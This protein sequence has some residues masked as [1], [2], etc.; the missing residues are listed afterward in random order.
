MAD[1]LPFALAYERYAAERTDA[2]AAYHHYA[3]VAICAA[4]LGNRVWVDSCW[5][6]IYPAIWLCFV[7]PSGTRKSTAVNLACGL[8]GE[9]IDNIEFPDDFSREAFYERLA[10]QPAGVLR[11]RELGSVLDVWG[12]DYMRGLSSTLT[13]FWDSPS[14][15]VREL[16]SGALAKD[17][18]HR[19]IVI[20]RPAISIIAA[21]K[22]AWFVE[23]VR[24]RDIEGGFISRWLFVLQH[25]PSGKPRPFL[26]AQRRDD[27]E[28]RDSMIAHLRS[29]AELEGPLLVDPDAAA[30]INSYTARLD[31]S[32]ALRSDPAD[33][34]G[35]AGT[36]II[37]LAMGISAS[38]YRRPPLR[39]T[40]PAIELAI[41]MYEVAFRWGC[42]LVELIQNQGYV[43]DK[44]R[45]L[46]EIMT[47]AG[48]EVTQRDIVRG[49]HMTIDRL[50]PLLETKIASGEWE[51][52]SQR[53]RHGRVTVVYRKVA[54]SMPCE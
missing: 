44:M 2:P 53:N 39:L 26:G 35:R 45:K 50:T 40:L 14:T 16:K 27:H 10:A 19:Q 13:D 42:E 18:H 3:A 33:F 12:L 31:T 52:V 28:M 1:S 47:A 20:H 43:P 24:R 11:W 17:N 49:M 51:K 7:G 9:A 46:D 6:R 38:Y 21:A 48:G 36:H 5:G 15:V 22:L 54:E 30:C 8:L 41:N 32:A 37:K 23:N 29:L 34:S 25:R 4:A